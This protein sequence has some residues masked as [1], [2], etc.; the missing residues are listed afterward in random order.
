MRMHVCRA[1]AC[2]LVL[3]APGVLA[4]QQSDAVRL[5]GEL[6]LR[7]EAERPA[8]VDTLD[9]FTLLRARLGLEASL[10]ERAKVF[11]QVQD[12]RTFGEEAGTM[13]AS[14]DRL[15]LHQGW[16]ELTRPL[17]ALQ[18]AL[19]AG[20]QEVTLGNERLI[21]PVGWTNTGR[22]F[23]ALRVSLGSAE[24][25]WQLTALAATVDE[26]GRR[27]TGTS[28]GP[29]RSD[30]ML[31][32]AW[33]DAKAIDAWFLFD[34]AAEYRTFYGVDRGTVGGRIEL[35]AWRGLTAWA[36]GSYQFGNMVTPSPLQDPDIAA[37]MF[38][39]RIAYA[40]PASPLRS[41]GAGLDYLSGDRDTPPGSEYQA[42]NVMYYTGHKWYGYLDL[43]LDPAART[44]DR[45]LVD[46]IASATVQLA[47]SAPLSIDVHHFATAVTRTINVVGDGPLPPA[48][49]QDLGWEFDLTLPLTV[50][51]NQRL[52]LG[53]SAYRN[54][55]AAP[56]AG[57][58]E[59]GN[60]WHWGYAMLT[61][62]FGG[63]VR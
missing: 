53:Y 24:Q 21:G 57:L 62:S 13:D 54:G 2:V 31:L 19:R 52:Q 11:L 47:A 25:Q 22:S 23:D 29:D 58:G 26:R 4:A 44:G 39:G 18:L 55:E 37:Y 45:G 49:A 36:E 10:G 32:G 35:P 48:E 5:L 38:G 28:P 34:R 51:P 61:F 16:L 59:D 7:G 60:W 1:V 12:A 50:G 9:A 63:S 27:L 46:W 15:D 8:L 6:R 33:I 30:H 42:F 40:L 43:F 17:G 56:L 14:A 41:L 20:R 3:G